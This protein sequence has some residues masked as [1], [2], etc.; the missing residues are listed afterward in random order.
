MNLRTQHTKIVNHIFTFWLTIRRIYPKKKCIAFGVKSKKNYPLIE[1][2]YVINLNRAPSRW[3]KIKQELRQI[4]DIQGNDIIKLTTRITAVDANTFTEEPEKDDKVDPFYTLSEQLSIEPQPSALPTH[5]ELNAPIRMSRAE[6]AVSRSHIKIWEQVIASNN[7]YS[8]ILEDDIWFHSNFAANLNKVWRDV[9]SNTDIKGSFDVLYL[10]YQ[11]VKHG[12]PKTILSKHLFRPERGLWHL[13]GYVI[14]REGAKKLVDLLPSRGPID[15]WIN[16]QFGSLNVIASRQSIIGQRIDI[17]SSNSYSI[18]PALTKIGAITSEGASLYNLR[19]TEKPIFVLGSEGSGN[20][21]VAMAISM[22][23]YRC[24]SDFKDLPTSEM[25]RLLDGNDD[26][27]F[28]S[29]VNIG[30][31]NS[32]VP[33]LILLYPKAKFILTSKK[34]AKM[35]SLFLD[36]NNSLKGT[37]FTVLYADAPNKWQILCEHLRCSPPR[38]NFPELIDIGQRPILKEKNIFNQKIKLTK[39]IHDDSPWLVQSKKWWHGIDSHQSEL[40]SDQKES[41]VKINDSFESLDQQV[42]L[43]R[44]DTF[45]DNLA[46]FRPSNVKCI[47]ELGAVLSIKNESMGVRNYSAASICSKDKFLYGKFE[48]TIQ[49]SNLPGVVTGFFLYRNSPRQEI[50]IE[51]LG[52]NPNLLLINVFYNPGDEG[53]KFDYGYR[54]SPIYVNLGFDASKESHRYAIQWGPNEIQWLVDDKIVHKRVVWDP[55]PIPHLPMT[56]HANI[57]ITRSS[58]LAGKFKNKK[59]PTSSVFKEIKIDANTVISM[60]KVNI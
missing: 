9:I 29:Y 54:G 45:T 55:T 24:C 6:C 20:T 48:A 43:A 17:T 53:A 14:S 11:E 57:W 58:K 15:L 2:V 25:I 46:L 22:L 21:S 36:L 39:T 35:D 16:H 23:G 4:L 40:K 33:E 47:P 8:L 51:I 7:E 3:T 34:E 28:D 56:L 60:S 52:N 44:S 37:D 42:W 18:L 31:L 27:I 19:P 49:A 38:S 41:V 10:S 32:M 5:L 26:R 30:S 59:L 12:A 1:K 50:D 13:S